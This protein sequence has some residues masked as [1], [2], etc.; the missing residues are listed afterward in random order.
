MLQTQ[1]CQ[2]P[3]E[4]KARWYTVSPTLQSSGARNS[5]HQVRDLLT[6]LLSSPKQKILPT[7]CT[8]VHHSLS[9]SSTRKHP[10]HGAPSRLTLTALS[11]LTGGGSSARGVALGVQAAPTSLRAAAAPRAGATEGRDW[12]GT[13]VWALGQAPGCELRRTFRGGA[14]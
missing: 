12:R 13:W 10:S 3:K 14:P 7:F 5:T 2:S 8:I 1:V 9:S 6:P 11:A 4:V